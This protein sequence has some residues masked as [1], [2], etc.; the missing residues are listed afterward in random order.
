MPNSEPSGCL[1]SIFKIFGPA[2]VND[3]PSAEPVRAG[4]PLPYLR[5]DW[6]FSQ[7]ERS[8]FGVLEQ[9]VGGMDGRLR[10]FAKVRLC[11]VLRIAK[12]TARGGGD[13]YR[14]HFNRINSKHVDFVICSHDE[15]QPLLAI[16]LDDSSHERDDRQE[17]DGFLDAACKAA[18]LPLLRVTCK[19]S[20]NVNDIAAQVRA[21]MGQPMQAKR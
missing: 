19:A 3:E 10:I 16:E 8:F 7:A 6:L 9:A 2:P 14:A 1:L 11:D 15:V 13:S 17:R 4:T 12:G 21:A 5:K 20:Y 18:G